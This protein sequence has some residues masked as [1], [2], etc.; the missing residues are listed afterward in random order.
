[1]LELEESK[2]DWEVFV[3]LQEYLVAHIKSNKPTEKKEAEE[4]LKKLV[5]DRNE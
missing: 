1:M 5:D 3:R 4:L 2:K